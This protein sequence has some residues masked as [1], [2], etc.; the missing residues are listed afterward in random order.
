M[1]LVVKAGLYLELIE[2]SFQCFPKK[3]KLSVKSFINLDFWTLILS[4]CKAIASWAIME[5]STELL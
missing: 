1:N 3:I 5:L 4:S 2:E